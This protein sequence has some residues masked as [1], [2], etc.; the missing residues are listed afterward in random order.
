VVLVGVIFVIE[1][2]I[3]LAYQVQVTVASGLISIVSVALAATIV[4][5]SVLMVGWA[6]VLTTFTFVCLQ[7]Q[8]SDLRERLLAATLYQILV[9]DLK[10]SAPLMVHISE[11]N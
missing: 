6:S 10:R 2:L 4:A 1:T 9:P 11:E 5:L 3:D 8:G 7:G